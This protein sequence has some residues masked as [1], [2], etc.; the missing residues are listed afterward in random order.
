MLRPRSA[1]SQVN[2]Q[3][4]AHVGAKAPAESDGT[5]MHLAGAGVGIYG[6]LK[7][8]GKYS[9]PVA[10]GVLGLGGWA[11]PLLVMGMVLGAE[12]KEISG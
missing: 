1:L 9:G 3:A 8:A 4:V 12:L 6:G 10:A 11:F 5:F 7:L 2:T